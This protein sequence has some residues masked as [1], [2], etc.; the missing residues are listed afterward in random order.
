MPA[1]TA[2]SRV[3][4]GHR[5]ADDAA[6]TRRIEHGLKSSHEGGNGKEAILMLKQR[7][8]YLYLKALATFGGRDESTKQKSL[9]QR[10]KVLSDKRI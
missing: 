8:E 9:V 2:F 3:P 7:N 6:F 1:R 10:I 4:A 5:R